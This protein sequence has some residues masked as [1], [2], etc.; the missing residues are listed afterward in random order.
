M[1]TI[2]TVTEVV[3]DGHGAD[4]STTGYT[5]KPAMERALR[6]RLAVDA[7][8][9]ELDV[10]SMDLDDLMELA[11]RANLEN[12]DQVYIV[13]TTVYDNLDEVEEWHQRLGYQG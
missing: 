10:D 5:S 11:E 13:E 2:W 1:H 12:E 9:E 3:Y 7:E 6:R 4:V 8:V